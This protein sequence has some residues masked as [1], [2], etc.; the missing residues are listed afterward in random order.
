MAPRIAVIVN[1]ASGRGRGARL[2]PSVREAFGAVGVT[3]IRLTERAGDESRVVRAALA[4]GAETIAIVGG[5]GTWGR[6]AGA[7]LDAGAGDK[8]RL[9]FLTGGT[10]N[11][12]AK[13]LGAP[14]TDFA[15]MARLTADPACERR[16][17][18]GAIECGGKTHWFLNVAGFGFDAVVLQDTSKGGKLGGNAVYIAAAL[19]RLIGYPG[20]AFTE[21]GTDGQTRFAMMLVFSNGT[22]F[23][24]AFRI[25]PRAKV[26]DGMF[27]LIEIGNVRGLWRIPLFLNAL[28][29]AHLSHSKV[30]ARRGARCMLAFT[31]APACDLDGELVQLSSRDVVVRMAPGALRVVAPGVGS[32]G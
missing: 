26:D 10:G 21:G 28:R 19:K 12:F 17:D 31:G 22:N 20:F 24:G 25:A 1:P 2:L 7:V 5:D 13:N 14:T 18:A 16:V 32:A 8:V 6:C 3:D 11:D 23:G 4:D 27:D 15:A 9:A 30:R 29:G